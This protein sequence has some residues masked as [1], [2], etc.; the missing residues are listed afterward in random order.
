MEKVATCITC[1]EQNSGA[2]RNLQEFQSQ[3]GRISEISDARRCVAFHYTS[4]PSLLVKRSVTV[5]A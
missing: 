4:R 3:V 5:F 1:D 2:N